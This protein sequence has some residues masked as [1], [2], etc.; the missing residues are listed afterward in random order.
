M[1]VRFAD[2]TDSDMKYDNFSQ[3]SNQ[4]S[5]CENAMSFLTLVDRED[6]KPEV[7][8]VEEGKVL[9]ELLKVKK[10]LNK[11]SFY[12]EEEQHFMDNIFVSKDS[13]N[14]SFS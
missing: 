2:M 13:I 11:P 7:S 3:L 6:F 12:T 10:T 8:K 1:K 9:R 4:I 5:D 14:I